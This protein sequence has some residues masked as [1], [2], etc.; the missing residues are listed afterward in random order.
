MGEVD[1]SLID[2]SFDS[3]GIDT[4]PCRRAVLEHLR[5]NRINQEIG[6]HV[7]FVV[8][9]VAHSL[10]GLVAKT[11][12]VQYQVRSRLRTGTCLKN[13]NNSNTNNTTTTTTTKYVAMTNHWLH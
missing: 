7:R 3:S 4:V 11:L 2:C 10:G 12:L 6:S 13:T 5:R 1:G 9:F 8:V